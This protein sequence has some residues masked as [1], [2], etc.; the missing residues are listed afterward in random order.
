[1]DYTESLSKYNEYIKNFKSTLE[2]SKKLYYNA[3]KN[4]KNA[5]EENK[6]LLHEINIKIPNF[7][8]KDN[9]ICTF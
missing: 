9:M 1:M 8:G 2:Y 4:L 5:L 6:R 3:K 7:Y